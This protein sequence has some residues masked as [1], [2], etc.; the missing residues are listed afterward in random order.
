MADLLESGESGLIVVAVNKW[1]AD[2]EP[3]L[4]NAEKS[5]VVNTTWGDL[6]EA[7]EKEIADAQ[8]TSA[9]HPNPNP[10]CTWMAPSTR[11]GCGPG[12]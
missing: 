12:L 4:L 3:L 1:G 5:I 9:H 6:D 2:I 7:I 10:A 8:S 11:P